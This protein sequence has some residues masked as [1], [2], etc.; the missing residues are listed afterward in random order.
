MRQKN[1]VRYCDM[2][3]YSFAIVSEWLVG[4]DADHLPFSLQSSPLYAAMRLAA[5]Q[6]G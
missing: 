2:T 4:Q 6:Q 3:P 1:S 5:A